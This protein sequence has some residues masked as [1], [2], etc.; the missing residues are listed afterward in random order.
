MK[1][2]KKFI[3]SFG[4]ATVLFGSYHQQA[5]AKEKESK[6]NRENPNVIFILADDLGYGDLSFLGQEKI[7]TPNIDR[8]A[9][10]G[11]AFTNFYSGNTVC[12]PS[13]ANLMTGQHPGH[14]HIRWNIPNENAPLDPDMITLPRVFKKA[15]YATGAFGKWGLGITTADGPQNPLENGFDVF[16]GWKSQL[17]AHTYYPSSIVRNG[18]EIPLEPGTYV[19]DLIMQD[20]FKFISEN[21]KEKKPFFCYIPTAIP[22]A[23]MHAPE[24]LHNKW[25]KIFPEF[26]GVIGTYG[27]GPDEECPPV[28]NP[29][30]G[31]AAMMEHLDNQVGTILNIL[32][33]HDVDDNTLIIFTSDNGPHMEGGHNPWFW[34]SNGDFR[35]YKRDFYEGGLHVPFFVRWPYQIAPQSQSNLI[36]AFWDILPTMAEI[37]GQKI[38]KQSDGISLFPTFLG[39]ISEQEK[40]DYL[41]WEANRDG[42]FMKAVR[43]KNWKAVKYL[44]DNDNRWVFELYDLETDI[45]EQHNIAD[46]HPDIIRKIELIMEEAH[47]PLGK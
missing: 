6:I 44:S 36:S 40:H 46:E 39:N 29:I 22:H 31:F 16:S 2:I 5:Q 3:L 23:A 11:M 43:M 27:A 12:S 45:G 37:T 38:P 14:V 21:A 25:R 17:I 47:V 9:R 33:K 34:D 10:E 30:A 4:L 41:Y 1:R 20:A 26:D 7:K 13:R 18:M 32:K 35:G 8:I 19:H 24:E 42:P 28:V 15:G